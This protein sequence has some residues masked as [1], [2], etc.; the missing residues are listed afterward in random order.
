MI[1]NV[2]IKFGLPLLALALVL[3]AAR[4]VAEM[5]QPIPELPPPIEPARNPFPSTL[6]AAGMIEP[7]TENINIGSPLTG[8][9]AEVDVKVGEQVRAGDPLFRIDDRQLKSEL[10]VRRAM[11]EDMKAVLAKLESMPRPEEIPAAEARVRE[12]AADY[13]NWQERVARDDKVFDKG[14]I[15]EEEFFNRKTQAAKARERHEKA[16]AD[17]ALL[18]KGA[19][20]PDKHKAQTAIDL[21]QSQI[22]QTETELDRLVVRAPVDGEVLQVNVRPGEFVGAPANRVLVM[23]GNTTRLHV[24]ADI[25]EYDIPRFDKSAKAIATLKGHPEKEFK[26]KFVRLEPFVVPKKSLTGDNTERVD[27]RVLQVIYAIEAADEALYVGQQLDVFI[28]A[29]QAD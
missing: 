27:T 1:S 29:K 8:V 13:Q 15:V 21:A 12:T 28:D 4:H 19:W 22:E 6:A 25:D 23:L 14:F 24:R 10:E 11:L 9:V 16:K 20:E 7:E 17:L 5:Q 18:K 3:Y 26:L 2:L